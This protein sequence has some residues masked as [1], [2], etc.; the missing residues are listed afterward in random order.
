MLCNYFYNFYGYVYNNKNQI[1]K[2]FNILNYN[3]QCNNKDDN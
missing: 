1:L 2:F 3:G